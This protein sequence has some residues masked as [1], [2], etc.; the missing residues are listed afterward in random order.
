MGKPSELK[1]TLTFD[2]INIKEVWIGGKANF[3]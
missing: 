1:A 2:D 3:K